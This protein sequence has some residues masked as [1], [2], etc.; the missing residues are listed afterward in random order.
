MKIKISF[1]CIAILLW[2]FIS[3]GQQERALVIGIDKYKETDRSPFPELD[4]CK[5]DALSMKILINA[6]YNFPNENIKALY[7]EQATRENILKSLKELLDKSKKGDIAFVFYAGHG[8][9]VKNSLN[10]TEDHLDQSIVPVDYWKEEVR[11]IRNKELAAVFDQFINKGVILTCIFDCC[12]SGTIDR[13]IQNTPPKFRYMPGSN[14]DAKDASNPIPPEKIKNSNY[15]ILAAVQ[16]DELE[17]EQ[18]D[19]NNKP[20][21]AFTLALLNA[22]KQ[23]DVNGSVNNLFTA[24]H[25]IL[26]SDGVVEEPVM[27][28]DVNRMEGTLF[29]L[30]KGTLTNKILI[31]VDSVI[32]NRV[33]VEAGMVI[34]LHEENELT[35]VN[36]NTKIKIT[37]IL[38]PDL[39]EGEITEGD[40]NIKPGELFEVTNWVSSSAPFLN[41]YIPDSKLNYQQVFQYA[42]IV[43]D[44]R[45]KIKMINDFRYDDPDISFYYSNGKWWYNDTSKGQIQLKDFSENNIL[46]IANDRKV[47]INIPAPHSLFDSLNSLL[48]VY[49][50]LQIVDNPNDAQY[51]L[52]GTVDSNDVLNYSLVRTQLSAKDSLSMMPVQTKIFELKGDN[53]ESYNYVTDS[54]AEY[55]IRLSKVRGWLN[56]VPPQNDNFPFK[57]ELRKHNSNQVIGNE[58]IKV[59]EQFDLYF[60][61]EKDFASR[62]DSKQRFIYVFDIDQSGTMSLLYPDSHSG[63]IT[64][65]PILDENHTPVSEKKLNGDDYY[66]AEPVGTD[67]YYLLAT[68]VA[69]PNYDIVFDQQ[70]VQSRGSSGVFEGLLNLGNRNLTRGV[71]ITRTPA[72]WMLQRIAVKTSH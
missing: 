14:W 12:H 53:D 29:G 63:N 9:E 25:A 6:K 68:D 24:L 1:L 15:L 51:A 23:Q 70:G 32:G 20:H 58:G 44:T 19:E 49:K 43:G 5:N 41:L 33:K 46:Q 36:G 55:A 40:K 56:L 3:R 48:S 8:S 59:G 50:N 60:V 64:K 22:I 21:G 31:P 30:S 57:L 52:Y 26:R 18:T 4:G 34:G 17:S 61:N 13:G 66:G 71:K 47:N 69:I 45:N 16:K 7:N 39:S 11:D 38:G 35:K 67:N 37:N 72:N 54:L 62:W 10:K 2:S 27:A 28:G 65:F 42:K